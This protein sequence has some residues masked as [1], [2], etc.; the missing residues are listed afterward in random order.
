MEEAKF[1]GKVLDDLTWLD[2][3]S[4]SSHPPHYQW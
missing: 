4:K 2:L 1:V 3:P